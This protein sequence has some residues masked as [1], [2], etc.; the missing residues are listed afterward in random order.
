MPWW[1]APLPPPVDNS[2]EKVDNP[3]A[4]HILPLAGP[5]LAIFAKQPRAGWV[6]TRLSPPLTPVQARDLY[7]IALEETVSRLATAPATRVLCHAGRHGWFARAFPGVLRL[8]QGRGDLGTR[9]ARVTAALFAAGGG[10][11]AVVGSD[12]PDLPLALVEEA[13]AALAGADAAVVASGDGGYAL[14]ALAAPQPGLFKGIPWS[15]SRVLA[16]TWERAAALGLRLE[17]VGSW[18]DVDDIASLQRLVTRSPA[19]ATACHVRCCLA[20]VLARGG[21]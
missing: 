17:N 12:S 19:S 20:P 13:F 6:K 5:L 1:S 3:T 2:V 21:D 11:V 18:D 9:L 10:P 8:A 4:G 7:R 15:T 14:L 16:A